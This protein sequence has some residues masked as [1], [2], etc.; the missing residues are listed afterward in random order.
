ML[1]TQ[2]TF[3]RTSGE[4]S[5]LDDSNEVGNSSEEFYTE[6]YLS[7]DDRIKLAGKILIRI[8]LCS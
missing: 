6:P 2:T 7:I 8:Q 4:E 1:L 3:A 5:F